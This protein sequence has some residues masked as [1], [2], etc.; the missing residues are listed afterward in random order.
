M[1]KALLLL[2]GL[3]PIA[4]VQAQWLSAEPYPL[5]PSPAD[6]VSVN[7]NGIGVGYY[8]IPSAGGSRA[9][10]FDATTFTYLD[11]PVGSPYSGATRVIGIDAQDVAYGSAEIDPQQSDATLWGNTGPQLVSALVTSGPTLDLHEAIGRLPSGAI[12]GTARLP[13]SNQVTRGFYLK[14]GV[15][16]EI[17]D[18]TQM[19]TAIPR[20]FGTVG[21]QDVVVGVANMESRLRAWT[22]TAGT[23]TLLPEP[24]LPNVNT[25]A[26][27]IN[28][29]GTVVGWYST[30]QDPLTTPA[31]PKAAKWHSG[32]FVDLHNISGQ[33]SVAL[34]ID[35][36]GNSVGYANNGADFAVLWTGLQ[37]STLQSLAPSGTTILFERAVTITDD[38]FIY[39]T[40]FFPGGF[41]SQLCE[42][43]YLNLGGACGSFPVPQLDPGPGCPDAGKTMSINISGGVPNAPGLFL[44]GSG[45]N[46]IPFKPWC[47][48]GV[49]PLIPVTFPFVVSSAGTLNIGTTLPATLSPVT[50]YAQAVL[51]DPAALG[52]VEVSNRLRIAIE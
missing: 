2:L 8:A 22:W 11:A 33:F 12:I 17:F 15:L 49:A 38:G 39:G 1:F 4:E 41:R 30:T 47:S 43:T 6:P 37:G 7:S 50:I 31:Y 13:G 51:A 34:A 35:S 9:I 10:R 26:I 29:A 19:V 23:F 27:A 46:T 21:G 16:T 14:N 48:L 3:V 24:A 36:A 45:N 44:I 25:S 20:G 28:S 40:D 32:A 5:L 18:D 42:G 52:G